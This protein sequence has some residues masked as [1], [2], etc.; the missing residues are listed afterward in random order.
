MIL[1]VLQASKTGGFT[2]C[3]VSS[4][5][6]TPLPILYSLSLKIFSSVFETVN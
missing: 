4:Y 6:Y 5:S 3:L 1:S 2:L